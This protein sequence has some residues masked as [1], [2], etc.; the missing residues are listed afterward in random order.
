VRGR[1]RNIEVRL[2]ER[3]GE[4]MQA[5]LVRQ[6]PAATEQLPST[7]LGTQ[8]G[9]SVPVDPGDQRGVKALEKL[10][11]LELA[12]PQA[13]QNAKFGGRVYVRFDHGWEPVAYRWVRAVR[14]LFLSEFNR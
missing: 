5:E 10:F 9:G 6:V 3:V 11:Q 14:Q 1:N 7:A 4:P 12:L 13:A 8:G 2:A